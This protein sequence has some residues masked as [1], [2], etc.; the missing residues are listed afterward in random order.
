MAAAA[1]ETTNIAT[2]LTPSSKPYYDKVISI[3]TKLETAINGIKKTHIVQSEYDNVG[4]E[5]PDCKSKEYPFTI[6]SQPIGT[7][8]YRNADIY[9]F[10]GFLRNIMEHYYNQSAEFTITNDV[11]I[12]I[13]FDGYY[14]RTP[15]QTSW[16]EDFIPFFM[17]AFGDEHTVSHPAVKHSRHRDYDYC[18]TRLVIDGIKFDI[19]SHINDFHPKCPRFDELSDYTVNNLMTDTNGNLQTRVKIDDYDFPICLGDIQAKRLVFINN[20]KVF[21]KLIGSY[22]D[23]D[24]IYQQYMEDRKQKMLGYGYTNA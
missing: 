11:D 24:T 2:F 12:F 18:L 8:E 9:I 17:T 4:K 5:W 20:S 1:T 10:G 13:R 15:S 6:Y 16:Y 22:P 19:T 23:T 7:P 3:I 14:V 21:K